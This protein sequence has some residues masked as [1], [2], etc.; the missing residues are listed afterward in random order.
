MEYFRSYL[1]KEKSPRLNRQ[2]RLAIY[3]VI[4]IIGV[5]VAGYNAIHSFNFTNSK[6][7][8][9]DSYQ[10]NT[11]PQDLATM[12]TDQPGTW[13]IKTDNSAP[14]PPNVLA[15]LPGNNNSTYHIQIMPD[16]PIVTEAE[17]SVKFKIAPGH[18]TEQAGLIV[19]FV[20]KIHYFVLIADPVNNRLSLCKS[21]IQFI[22][23]NYE[24]TAQISVG[25]WHTLKAN[26]SAQ[27]I[28][29]YLDDTE[30]IKANNEY[31]QNGQIGLW[32][33]GDTEAYFDDLK[34]NY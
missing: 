19:R 28:G 11:T 34:L 30:L 4:T 10:N 18:E 25:Q 29:G 13:V 17:V 2:R 7:W 22:V 1:S 8:N 3:A 14:S 23:C 21:D 20:D 33:K 27:G 9:F 15:V 26:I 6:D 12:E 32:T 24:S 31:Y 5:G 16:S